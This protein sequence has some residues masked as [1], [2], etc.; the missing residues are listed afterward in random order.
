M[1]QVT[2]LGISFSSSGAKYD[3][4]RIKSGGSYSAPY[5]LFRTDVGTDWVDTFDISVAWY[6]VPKGVP[7]GYGV[8][9]SYIWSTVDGDSA[10]VGTSG[11]GY[12]WR[13]S[14]GSIGNM[15]QTTVT[16]KVAPSGWNYS[17]RVND[18]ISF[19][20]HVRIKYKSGKVDQFGGTSSSLYEREG[21]V[22][23][24]QPNY[25]LAGL[26]LSSAG[27]SVTYTAS[28]WTRNDD[29][30]GFSTLQQNG[31]EF[32][33]GGNPNTVYGTVDY[34]PVSGSG[35]GT[36]TIPY[37]SLRATPD[38]GPTYI[39]VRMVP[40]YRMVE[41]TLGYIEGT[42]TMS[43]EFACNTPALTLVSVDAY[44]LLVNVTDR[45]DKGSPIETACVSLNPGYDVKTCSPGETVSFPLPPLGTT[46]YIT[47]WGFSSNGS[48]SDKATREVPAIEPD[49]NEQN[50]FYISPVDQGEIATCRF[51]V[52]VKWQYEAEM[53]VVKFSG[54]E[55]ESVAYGTGGPVTGTVE[56]DVI[57][58][59]VRGSETPWRRVHAQEV[60]F[61]ETLPY[62]GVCI[63]RDNNGD[64]RRV[65]VEAVN[66]SW[67][68][69]NFVKTMSITLREVD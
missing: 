12:E 17:Q 53:E 37:S 63:Y 8:R 50:V 61:F 32:R 45:G 44:E 46:I 19:N 18:A 39:R 60:G 47:A 33:V 5:I 9:S 42:T 31:V 56:C 13:T 43:S 3:E 29:R 27:L 11:G 35:T 15:S 21:I 20:I 25:K 34:P 59:N 49:S 26:A 41:D 6:V 24:Y 67:D 64:R 55:R 22:V 68:T 38:A 4:L 40:S 48:Q 57:D 65:A 30:W 28:G 58:L 52:S 16:Q 62:W 7:G 14:L 69:V 1:P 10:Y 36:I 2:D 23:A 54:R 51:N 66:E